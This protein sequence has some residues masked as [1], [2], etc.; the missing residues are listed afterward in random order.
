[1]A[2]FEEFPDPD[3]ILPRKRR[4]ITINRPA[5]TELD[6]QEI[7]K[8]NVKE[9]KSLR[10]RFTKFLGKHKCSTKSAKACFFTLFPIFVWLPAYDVK[11]DL[12]GDFAS[13]L[14]VGIMRL[15]QGM[16]YGL[17]ATLAPVYGLYT[18][19]FPA[20]LYA[21]MGTSRHLSVGSFAVVSIMTAAAVDR[22][23]EETRPAEGPYN[24]G[25][26]RAKIAAS[27]AFLVGIFQL[28][29]GVLRLGFVSTYLAEPLVRGF[30]TGAAFHVFNSQF[31][32]LFGIEVTRYNGP[33]AIYKTFF[34]LFANLALT[35]VTELIIALVNLVAL[36]TVKELQDKYKEKIKY[37]I[38]LELLAI[39]LTTMV[40]HFASLEKKYGA[41]VVGD[42][43]TGLP[44]PELPSFSHMDSLITDAI[45]ISIVTFSVSVSM[46]YIFAKR[47]NY[48]IDANQEL[49]ALGSMSVFG[50]FFVCYPAASSLSRSLLQEIS[51][52]KTQSCLAAIVVVALRGMFR[53]FRDIKVLWKYSKIDC[54]IWV[55]TWFSTMSLGVD[56]GLGVGVVF[57]IM[58]VIIR[59]QKPYCCLMGR[60]PG[61][62]IYRDLSYYQSAKQI[63]G[64]MIFRMHSPLYYAN[65]DYVKASLYSKSQLNPVKILMARAKVESKK[66]K[67]ERRTEKAEVR[68][69]K[70]AGKKHTRLDEEEMSAMNVSDTT[71]HHLREDA[72][73]VIDDNRNSNNRLGNGDHL[74]LEMA[75]EDKTHSLVLDLG[76]VSFLDTVGISALKSI[77]ADYEKIGITVVMAHCKENV[78]EMLLG[79]GFMEQ[80]GLDRMFVTLHD[81][82]LQTANDQDV[83]DMREQNAWEHI[84]GGGGGDAACEIMAI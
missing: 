18:V 59:T 35:N 5:F 65:A 52:G 22:V 49:V 71:N 34:F 69:R 20:L 39:I 24:E 9:T 78:R 14:T 41:N 68:R 7:H 73:E 64:V 54:M 40:S 63:P 46:G 17:L 70:K 16:A 30:T 37:P 57:A 75:A 12:L 6:F 45:I 53:Q 3:V 72:I 74:S 62:D 82:I 38:P 50:C 79:S 47:N 42:I 8:E 60:I 27:L 15:P 33:F 4:S 26:E 32:Y 31:K 11:R 19:F 36:V 44:T 13:G 1:M 55:V 58:T 51:G 67:A 77:I 10:T 23:V 61:T 81:A 2:A 25:L 43:P 84:P 66:R 76:S 48:E 80:V 21:M 83:E 29:L 28:G 56:Y